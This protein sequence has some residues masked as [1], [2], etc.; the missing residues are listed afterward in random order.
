MIAGLAVASGVDTDV[1]A[2]SIAYVLVL[3]LLGPLSAKFAEPITDTLLARKARREE[4]A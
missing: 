4:P 3:A 1:G 2:L